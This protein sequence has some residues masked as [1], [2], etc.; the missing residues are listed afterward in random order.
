MNAQSINQQ[1]MNKN[2]LRKFLALGAAA[3]AFPS[4]PWRS[5]HRHKF[6]PTRAA[7]SRTLQTI[8]PQWRRPTN[9]KT[10]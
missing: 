6:Q 2:T 5:P 7:L 3:A 4:S 9:F 10:R 1:F 8:G